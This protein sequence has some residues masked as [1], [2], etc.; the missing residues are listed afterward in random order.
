MEEIEEAPRCGGCAWWDA[1]EG[2]RRGRCRARPPE[3]VPMGL[4]SSVKGEG[5]HVNLGT[6]WPMTQPSDWCGAWREEL[7]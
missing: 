3:V 6:M 2:A 5:R 1:E 4:V 7:R